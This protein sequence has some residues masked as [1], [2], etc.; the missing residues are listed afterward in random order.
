MQVDCPTPKESN[1]NRHLRKYS[2]LIVE[3]VP[4]VT[5]EIPWPVPSIK[6]I[7]NFQCKL[8]FSYRSDF[9]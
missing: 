5:E 2:S 9:I 7:I 6:P 4:R 8:T 3:I 1:P